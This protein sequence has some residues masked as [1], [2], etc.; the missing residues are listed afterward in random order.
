MNFSISGEHFLFRFEK[1]PVLL[2]VQMTENNARK[3]YRE[4]SKAYSKKQEDHILSESSPRRTFRCSLENECK[5]N[6][7]L[8]LGWEYGRNWL[9]KR[10]AFYAASG[11]E[12]KNPYIYPDIYFRTKGHF[13]KYYR[14]GDR[15]H[16]HPDT[17]KTS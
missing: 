2:I 17:I 7:F 9:S 14:K 4:W 3:K 10:D 8:I 1:S 13:K 12:V 11:K 6:M 15:T 16:A 5:H